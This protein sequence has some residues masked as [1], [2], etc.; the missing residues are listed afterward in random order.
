L[1]VPAEG[2]GPQILIQSTCRKVNA[3]SPQI[4]D[5]KR[6]INKGPKVIYHRGKPF[7]SFLFHQKSEGIW[8]LLSAGT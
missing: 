8:H 3:K 7:V 6:E 4:F 1:K 5:E 2:K